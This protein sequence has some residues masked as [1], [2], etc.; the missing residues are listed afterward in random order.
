MKLVV[1]TSLNI[2]L[3]SY[4]YTY[5]FMKYISNFISIETQ[6]FAIMFFSILVFIDNFTLL[7]DLQNIKP[8][9]NPEHIRIIGSQVIELQKNKMIIDKLTKL[10]EQQMIKHHNK[11]FLD[12][13]FNKI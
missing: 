7:Y 13:D 9:N 2:G 11:K 6:I 1:I 12:R 10:N 5:C 4:F 8:I 3:V